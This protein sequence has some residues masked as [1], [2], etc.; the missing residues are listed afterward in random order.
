MDDGHEVD[1]GER[2]SQP[3]IHIVL[4]DDDLIDGRLMEKALERRSDIILQYFSSA[5]AAQEL[6]RSDVTEQLCHVMLIDLEMPNV[7]GFELVNIINSRIPSYRRPLLLAYSGCLN[8]IGPE[9]LKV[10]DDA[11]EKP[12]LMSDLNLMIDGVVKLAR[13]RMSDQKK[14]LVGPSPR[15]GL[16]ASH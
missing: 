14:A 1:M 16:M 6:W 2:S 10:F 7:D 11:V 13:D 15:T 12:I 4:V 8:C 3:P 5:S 9:A